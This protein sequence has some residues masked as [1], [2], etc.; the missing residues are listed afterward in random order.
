MVIGPNL[1]LNATKTIRQQEERN[2]A[3][4]H[5]EAV[6]LERIRQG[7]QDEPSEINSEFYQNE[8]S[9]DFSVQ[10]SQDEFTCI[11]PILKNATSTQNRKD[12]PNAIAAACRFG[13]S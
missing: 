6:E 7:T 9:M 2:V 1:D 8:D 5:M 12:Y 10:S 3:R 13:I 11:N 4:I